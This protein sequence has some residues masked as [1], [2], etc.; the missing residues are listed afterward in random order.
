MND[1]MQCPFK[2][3]V[4][5]SGCDI[6]RA[7]V[8]RRTSPDMARPTTSVACKVLTRNVQTAIAPN[9][10]ICNSGHDA[11]SRFCQYLGASRDRSAYSIQALSQAGEAADCYW[12]D[13]M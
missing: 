12:P 8:S 2:L 6:C 9:G 7:L 3:H 5:F 11:I 13:S 10:T 4:A 1:D